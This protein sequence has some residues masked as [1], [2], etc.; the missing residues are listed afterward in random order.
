MTC[1]SVASGAQSFGARSR[2]R[3]APRTGAPVLERV[4]TE[5][6]MF[7]RI[8][9]LVLAGCMSA[10]AALAAVVEPARAI[11]LA[12]GAGALGAPTLRTEA[13]ELLAR[14]SGSVNISRSGSEN[15]MVEIA[16]SVFWGALAGLAVGSA[17][18]LAANGQ[19]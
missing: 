6:H 14:S 8:L 2:P 9:A 15:P 16:R 18:T 12:A 7:R 10:N 13:P 1:I 4:R 5:V 11:T 3:T 17:I 19:S